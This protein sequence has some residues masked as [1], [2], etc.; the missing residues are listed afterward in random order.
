M[1]RIGVVNLDVSHPKAFSEYLRKGTRARYA[2]V[3]NDG[4]RGDDEVKAFMAANG[5]EKRSSSVA[6]LAQE[7]DIG[8]V[9]GCNWD[10]HLDYARE[11]VRAGKPVFI[12]KPI[13]G[14]LR[15][16]LALEQLA[17]DGAVIYGSSSLRYADEVA[18]FAAL[19]VE[20]RGEI[21][22]VTATV[23]VDEFNYA[24]HAV[25]T[26]MG[27]LGPDAR[28]ESVA[29]VGRSGWEKAGCDSYFVRFKNGVS[30]CYH[31]YLNTWQASTMT[32]VTTKKTVCT[33]IDAGV[34]YG[35]MLDR[36]CDM[37]DGKPDRIVPVE[38]L[39]E[40]I[41]IMLA[42]RSSRLKGGV[43]VRL[44]ELSVEDEG[45]DGYAFEKGYAAAAS[46]IYLPAEGKA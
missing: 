30:A 7:V 46:K 5:I 13:V 18:S 22:H 26:I 23:G 36:I 12:D 10:K 40:S 20:E 21:V 29:Y 14:N 32:V 39:T 6:E 31:I 4:F 42:G 3:F 25:E 1:Y 17:R 41:K 34:A 16:C 38:S 24:I 37:L 35:A 43:P 19:P 8:F 27:L 44:C 33:V 9:Q 11:F 45:F 2:A 15:D 28:A